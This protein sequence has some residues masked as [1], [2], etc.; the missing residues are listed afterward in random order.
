MSA[1]ATA[2][3]ASTRGRV[4]KVARG[5]ERTAARL[6]GDLIGRVLG[7]GRPAT[8]VE[9]DRDLE[10]PMADGTVLL[11]DRWYPVATGSEEAPILLARLPYGRGGLFGL[12]F[13]AFAEQGY[14]VVAV[15]SRGT[16]GSGGEW[17]PVPDRTGRRR[18]GAGLAARPAV[19][20]ARTSPPPA[21]ATSG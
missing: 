11:A 15:S 10:I 17:D 18:R 13:R 5:V 12:L 8:R 16:F 14:Q 9:V 6:R 1:P 2:G 7:I 3:P 21:A 20:R 19:V 4:R